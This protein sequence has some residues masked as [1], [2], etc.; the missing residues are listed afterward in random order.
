MANKAVIDKI[1]NNLHQDEL[2]FLIVFKTIKQE[3]Q[4]ECLRE[5][6]IL[7]NEARLNQECAEITKELMFSKVKTPSCLKIKQK[8]ERYKEKLRNKQ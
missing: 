3:I 5:K 7:P 4:K 2:R 8:V 1:T 6:L